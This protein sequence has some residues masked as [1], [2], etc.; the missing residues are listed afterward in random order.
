MIRDGNRVRQQ[1]AFK[2]HLRLFCAPQTI[3]IS[4]TE[5]RIQGKGIGITVTIFARNR[6]ESD[7]FSTEVHYFLDIYSKNT[8]FYYR[9][10]SDH[11]INIVF[12]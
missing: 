11:A 4:V 6:W 9:H 8:L 1:K 3:G 7:K 10:Y 2:G 5:I 12:S